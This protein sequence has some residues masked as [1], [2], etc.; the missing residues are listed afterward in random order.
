LRRSSLTG[1]PYPWLQ[2]FGYP[3][4]N[5]STSDVSSAMTSSV[6]RRTVEASVAPVRDALGVSLAV[7]A[8]VVM[9]LSAI[10]FRVFRQGGW[11]YY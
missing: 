8:A 4:R 9:V 3:V 10:N 6:S 1:P 5:P 7:L 2:R 11:T